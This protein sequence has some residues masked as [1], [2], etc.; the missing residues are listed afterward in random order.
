[1]GA[2]DFTSELIGVIPKEQAEV[3]YRNIEY[4][5]DMVKNVVIDLLRANPSKYAPVFLGDVE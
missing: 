3:I 5:S 2:V 1:M 4:H